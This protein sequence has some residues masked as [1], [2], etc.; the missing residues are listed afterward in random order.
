MRWISGGWTMVMAI[1]FGASPALTRPTRAPTTPTP[2]EPAVG[3]A[4]SHSASAGQPL[5]AVPARRAARCG[6]LSSLLRVFDGGD[7]KEG[8]VRPCPMAG[9]AKRVSTAFQLPLCPPSNTLIELRSLLTSAASN[10]VLSFR[11]PMCCTQKGMKSSYSTSLSSYLSLSDSESSEKSTCRQGRTTDGAAEEALV[12]NKP[13]LSKPAVQWA[14]NTTALIDK[15]HRGSFPGI[16]HSKIFFD[17]GLNLG[18]ECFLYTQDPD[19]ASETRREQVGRRKLTL[20]PYSLMRE[21]VCLHAH[22]YSSRNTS[23]RL[24]SEA[25]YLATRR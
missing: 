14:V 25:R 2:K 8:S 20:L 15:F 13:R 7:Y 17:L 22:L 4:H 10:D 1:R 5:R 19:H 3:T 16:F 12:Q 24:P 11:H 21:S 9:A 6:R 18:F 23:C